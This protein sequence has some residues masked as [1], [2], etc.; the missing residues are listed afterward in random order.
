MHLGE[1]FRCDLQ[2]SSRQHICSKG[3]LIDRMKQQSLIP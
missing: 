2:I 1:A 3:H